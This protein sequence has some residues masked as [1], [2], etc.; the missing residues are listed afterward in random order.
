MIN[1]LISFNIVEV[2]T[3]GYK[4]IF[5]KRSNKIRQIEISIRTLFLFY[6]INKYK[7]FKK[8]NKHIRYMIL[9]LI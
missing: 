6:F 8:C 4:N 1:Y 2:R 7:L 5:E 3:N 9:F